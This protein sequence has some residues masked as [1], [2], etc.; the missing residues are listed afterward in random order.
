MLNIENKI[1]VAASSNS[2]L[3]KAKKLSRQLNLQ[4][5]DYERVSSPFLLAITPER[6]ELQEKNTKN[7]KPIYVDF[8]APSIDYRMQYG[9][10]NKQLIAKAIGIKPG[11]R[12]TVLDTTA[13]LGIDAFVLASLGCDV[14]MLERSPIIGALLEDG[15]ERF[16]KTVQAKNIKLDL[17]LTQAIDYLNK[18]SR[19]GI[20]KPDVIYLD[21][22]YP[23]RKKAAL[24]KKTM[25]ILHELVG[26]DEDALEVFNLALKCTKKRVVVKRP[27]YAKNLGGLKPDLK[28]SSGGSGRFDVYFADHGAKTKR[29]RL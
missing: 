4:L 25:R 2:A 3:T 12:P 11:I 1:A 16:R 28:F 10:G 22:M 15:L 29:C 13:G 5:I 23:E 9:G 26:A 21:P 14:V 7:S 24:G 8:L 18:I 27:G 17:H 19:R 20:K 6:L